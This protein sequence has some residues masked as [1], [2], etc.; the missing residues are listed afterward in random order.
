[1]FIDNSNECYFN[2][3]DMSLIT[4]RL[5]DAI[6]EYNEDDESDNQ[7]LLSQVLNIRQGIAKLVSISL[8]KKKTIM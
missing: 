1:M 8:R 7:F 5:D 3:A 4:M 2:I 6:I